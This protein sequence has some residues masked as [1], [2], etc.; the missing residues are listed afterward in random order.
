M[1][2]RFEAEGGKHH[3]EA[4]DTQALDRGGYEF[5]GEGYEIMCREAEEKYCYQPADGERAL[6]EQRG[7]EAKQGEVAQ[8]P[9]GAVQGDVS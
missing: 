6:H 1:F 2:C 4:E 3:T 7:D 9:H 5:C 8:E